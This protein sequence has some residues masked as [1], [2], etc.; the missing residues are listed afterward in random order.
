MK[1]TFTPTPSDAAA[2]AEALDAMANPTVPKGK[3]VLA[4]LL[5]SGKTIRFRGRNLSAAMSFDGIKVIE[6]CSE[7]CCFDDWDDIWQ[8]LYVAGRSDSDIESYY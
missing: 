3:E 7:G 4:S 5:E 1:P 8:Y 2:I 6:C